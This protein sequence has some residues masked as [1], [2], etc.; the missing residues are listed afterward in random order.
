MAKERIGILG[1][2]FDPIHDGHINMALSA[3][4]DANLDK[5]L[6]LP[7][8]CPPHKAGI[9]PAEDRWKMVCCACA[10]HDELTP[11]RVELDREGTIYTVDTLKILQDMNPRA[12]MFYLI[13]TDTLMEL[14]T[15]RSFEEVLHLCT[16]IIC[17]RPTTVLPKTLAEEQHRLTELGGHFIALDSPIV[18]ISSTEIRQA[19]GN[20]QTA[21]HCSTPVQEYANA[22]GLYGA[23]PRIQ[24]AK[25]WIEH[26]YQALNIRRFAH[27]LSVAYTARQLALAHHLD[28]VKAEKAGLLHDC[29]KCLPLNEMQQ[30]CEKHHVTVDDGIYQSTALLHSV[31]G[32]CLVQDE[33]SITD[34]EIISAIANHTS[35]RPGMSRLDMVI[36]L[37]DKIEPTRTPYPL[38]NR[39]R[40]QAPLSLEKAMLTSLEGSAEYLTRSGK[41][42]HPLSLQTIDWLKSNL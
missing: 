29:A 3:L 42:V 26:L 37:A 9:T 18:D 20:G 10:M 25:T 34:P 24:E 17:P 2:T 38:L 32:A 6:V 16:F 21:P 35:G 23:A 39:M 36:W 12:E 41:I 8:G 30:L 4:K 14:H 22:C 33:Y 28:A 13:G 11:S 7:T 1:G 15:W 31:A 19:I 40:M 27:S 5:V